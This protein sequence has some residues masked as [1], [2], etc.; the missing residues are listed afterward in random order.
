MT[1]FRDKQYYFKVLC[2][3][4]G[5]KKVENKGGFLVHITHPENGVS[6]L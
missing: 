4:F 2:L 5:A 6:S 1:Y 3:F